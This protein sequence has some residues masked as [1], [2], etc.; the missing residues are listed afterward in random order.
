MISPTQGGYL[1]PDH[2]AWLTKKLV[3]SA[4][5][6]NLNVYSYD[7]QKDILLEHQQSGASD[8]DVSY[9]IHVAPDP[10]REATQRD[11]KIHIMLPTFLTTLDGVWRRLPV[12][13]RFGEVL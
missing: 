13:R 9:V 8:L 4:T 7:S 10:M 12:I 3:V 5:H 2:N 1:K 11:V 6:G